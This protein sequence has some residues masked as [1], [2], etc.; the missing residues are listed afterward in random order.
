MTEISR[1]TLF[2][3]LNPV[4][5]RAIEGATV[6][7]KLRGNPYVELV[8]W[9]HQILQA[10]DSDLHRIVRHFELDASRLAADITAALD[11]LPRG[12][13]ADL[14]LLAAHRGGDRARLGARDADVR[15]STRC[16]PAIWCWAS[17]AH[18]RVC[19]TCCWAS[20]GSSTA[21]AAEALADDGQDHR[22]GSPEEA[23]GSHRRQSAA[24]GEAS[25]AVA[26]A[27]DGQG[28]GAGKILGRPD[29]A[30]AQGRDGPDRRAAMPKSARWSTC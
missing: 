22:K 26:P 19:A 6:F 11:K 5:Y 15:A 29:R 3:K 20:A 7:C 4:A 2:G 28:R 10:Q 18:A 21:S 25:G 14:R 27:A 12:A 16:A 24:P 8:H 23:D 9:L 1:S 30:G 17:C 13:T